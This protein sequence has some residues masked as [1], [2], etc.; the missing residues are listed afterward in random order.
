MVVV[1]DF[2]KDVLKQLVDAI[3]D[4]IKA[5]AVCL[6]NETDDKLMYLCKTNQLDAKKMIQKAASVSNGSGGGRPDF[7]QG[8]TS[9]KSKL[10][11]I[12][13]SFEEWFN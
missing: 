1:K 5:E 4:K 9:D 7:A 12:I 13:A 2:D 10:Q 6:I 3:Y 11:A 8:G